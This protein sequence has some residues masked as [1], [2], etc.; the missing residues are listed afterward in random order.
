MKKPRSDYLHVGQANFAPAQVKLEV[1]WLSAGQVK[2]VSV[3]SLVINSNQ[4][5]FQTKDCQMSK[6]AK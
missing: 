6:G 4:K 3:V 2:E 1:W 5:Q